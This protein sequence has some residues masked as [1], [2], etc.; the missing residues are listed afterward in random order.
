MLEKSV[1][2]VSASEAAPTPKSPV[3]WTTWKARNKKGVEQVVKH[4]IDYVLYSTKGVAVSGSDTTAN[5][6]Q[7]EV[8][9]AKKVAIEAVGTAALFT[10]EEV[11][12]DLFPS[13]R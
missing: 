5:S 1:D 7:V 13:D 4:C 6:A 10:D 3:V 2:R 12:N 9:S 11:G 8:S